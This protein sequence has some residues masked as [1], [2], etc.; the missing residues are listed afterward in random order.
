MSYDEFM[1][2]MR[3]KADSYKVGRSFA[4]SF[5]PLSI[6]DV[7]ESYLAAAEDAF[8]LIGEGGQQ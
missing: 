7:E 4:L 8:R 1:E 2:I 3:E 5:K 6:N